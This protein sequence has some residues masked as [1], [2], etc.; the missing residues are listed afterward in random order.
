MRAPIPLPRPANRAMGDFFG[1]PKFRD[2]A[3]NALID[4]GYGLTRAP[5]IGQAFGA[6]T[7]HMVDQQPARDAYAQSE[8]EKA[9]R[10][11]QINQTSEYLRNTF[12]DL[13]EAVNA[14]MPLD[15]AWNEAMKRSQPKGPRDPIKVGA[16]ET[17]L[18]PNTMQPLYTGP[19]DQKDQFGYEKDL[20]SQY[21]AA[22]PVKQYQG[23]KA[24]Y[25]KLQQAAAQG[26]GPGD[27]S[28]IFGFMKMLDPTSTVREGEYASAQNSGGIPAQLQ[29]LYNKAID[30][31]F[32]TPAQRD[33]FLRTAESIYT[34]S[35]GNL[36][37]TNQQFTERAGGYGVDP[38]R[39]IV[40]PEDF[41]SG[42]WV[43]VEPGVRIRKK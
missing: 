40:K 25:E 19:A 2:F 17:L 8:A 12:P 24:G 31:Q 20:Y 35:V 38:N 21:T 16:G 9:E 37:A 30:G 7:Q 6:A 1:S 14:G 13:A 29:G 43:Q 41:K 27:M 39:F 23:I 15:S 5:D 42:K 22:D 32:L 33:E 36:E 28:L 18:D 34:E 4:L 10:L 11:A 26:S 3:S